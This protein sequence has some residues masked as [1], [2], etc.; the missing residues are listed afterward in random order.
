QDVHRHA[1]THHL[2]QERRRAR[3]RHLLIGALESRAHEIAERV[4]LRAQVRLV[5]IPAGDVRRHARSHSA[6]TASRTSLSI[7]SVTKLRT[8]KPHSRPC[9]SSTPPPL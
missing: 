3:V 8:L 4:E 1:R 9:S 6:V 5:E 2:A 7:R